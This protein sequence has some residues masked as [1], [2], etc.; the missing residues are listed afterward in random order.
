MYPSSFFAGSHDAPQRAV[1]IYSLLETCEKNN[2]EPS[3]LLTDVLIS[4]Q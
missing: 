4:I 3:K 1:V 2:I